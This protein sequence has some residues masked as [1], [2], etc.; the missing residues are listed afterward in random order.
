MSDHSE[1]YELHKVDKDVQLTVNRFANHKTSDHAESGYGAASNVGGNGQTIESV[2]RVRRLFSFSQIFAFSL[3]FMSTWE[4]MNT[5]M[6]F[7]LYNGGPQTFAWSVVIVYF[8]AIAQ[9]ASIAEMASTIPIAGAQYHWTYNLAPSNMKRFITWM[10]GWMTWFGWV[11]LLAGIANITAII[12]QQL[13]MLNHP[14]YVPETWHIT[15]IM[16]AILLVQGLINSF[17]TTFAVVPWLEL[18]AGILHVCLFVL[19]LVV[20]VVMGSRHSA[21]FIFLERSISSGWTDTYIA[22]NLGMLTCAWSFTGFDDS[23]HLSEETKKAPQAV[24]RATFWSIALNGVLAYAM[25]IAIL[26]AMGPID[27]VLNSG[28]PI[29]TILLRVTGSVKATTAMVCGLFVISFC[30]NIAS[31]ASVSRLTWAWSRDGGLPRWFALVDSTHHVPIRSIW[32]SLVVVML[33][34]LLNIGSTTAFGAITAL[35]SLALYF[36]Y[37]TAISAMLLARWTSSHGGKPLE[38]GGWNLGRYG[39][40]I[41]SFALVYTLYIMVFLPIP[42]TLPVT[43]SNMNYAGPIFLFVFFFAIAL[44]FLRA[45]KHWPG[46]NVAVIDFVKAQE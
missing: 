44:W 10:Q 19:F 40:Y 30:V 35:S 14:S 31:I 5:N 27:E 1:A 15:L 11:S 34:S 9:A 24:P 3:T 25:V 32:L 12:L 29:I 46:P 43:A 42:S 23:C 6:F 22:W 37:G 8:G 17:G 2:T 20:L 41:N 38:L 4:G 16:I 13:A 26:S 33:L 45:R 18:V 21:E 28:F 7:A 39:V 36:S